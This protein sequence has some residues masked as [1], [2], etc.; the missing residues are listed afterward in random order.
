MKE[1]DVVSAILEVWGGII[2]N[3]EKKVLQTKEK[4]Y[5]KV[6][7]NKN[8]QALG[9]EGSLGMMVEHRIHRDKGDVRKTWTWQKSSMFPIALRI[10]F[11]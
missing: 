1:R 3:K 6:E 2:Q 9:P 7:V 5:I 11:F 10:I 8:W 4:A